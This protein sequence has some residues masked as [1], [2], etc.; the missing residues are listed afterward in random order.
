MVKVKLIVVTP[1]ATLG[2]PPQI[3]ME[4][5]TEEPT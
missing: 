3:K 1:D 4:M 2:A 5:L